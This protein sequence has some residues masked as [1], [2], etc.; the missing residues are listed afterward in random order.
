MYKKAMSGLMLLNM[1]ILAGYLCVTGVQ[2]NRIAATPAFQ[3]RLDAAYTADEKKSTVGMVYM[4]AS[5]QRVVD[6]G[7]ME[8]ENANVYQLEEEDY[9]LLLRI[10]QAEAGSEDSDGKLL[11]AN[12]VLNR[13]NSDKF[14]DSVSEVVL[15]QSGGVTQFSPVATG[16][17]WKVEVTQETVDAVQRALE[18]EDI[19][20]GALY[21]AARKYADGDKMRWFDEHLT[22]LFKHGG[23]EFFY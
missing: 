8:Q 5:G 17:I 19:S 7:V 9:N 14:P 22:F 18:G 23:H 3:M 16:S 4:A 15:Q 1:L 11:V 2:A 13:M 10:V 21:F 6:F 12:V 20:Q